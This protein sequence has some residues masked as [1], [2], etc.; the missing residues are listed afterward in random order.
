LLRTPDRLRIARVSVPGSRRR[1]G[2]RDA[3]RAGFALGAAL[4]A[5]GVARLL[6]GARA[7]T[8]W[9]GLA[10]D[11]FLGPAGRAL[12][13]LP[14]LLLVPPIGR[15]ALRPMQGLGRRLGTGGRAALA[16]GL[17]ALVPVLLL[18][19]RL[20]FIGDFILRQGATENPWRGEGSMFQAMPL[21][22]LIHNALPAALSGGAMERAVGVQRAVG[23]L[24]AAAFGATVGASLFSLGLRG[25]PLVTAIAGVAGSG[26]LLVFTGLGKAAGAMCALSIAAVALAA[27]VVRDGRGLVPLGLALGVAFH[28]HRSAL[29]LLP[30]WALACVAWWRTPRGRGE[31]PLAEALAGLG[32]PVILG[33]LVAPRTLALLAGFDL[34]RHAGTSGVGPGDW[35][36]S[37]FRLLRLTDLANAIVTLSPFAALAVFAAWARRRGAATPAPS[38]LVVSAALAVAFVLVA[39]P[40]QGIPR[41]LDAF[42]FAAALLSLSAACGI[43][44]TLA[45]AARWQWL[46]PALATAV[47]VPTLQWLWLSHDEDRGLA[48]VTR[49][50]ESPPARGDLERAA[51]WDFVATHQQLRGRWRE[52]L[53]AASHAVAIAPSPRLALEW[54]LAATRAGDL[55]TAHRAFVLLTERSPGDPVGW[56]GRLGAAQRLGREDEARRLIALL[57]A[58]PPG[59]EAAGRVRGFLERYPEI[60]PRP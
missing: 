40:Q 34:P 21:D 28:F 2:T 17:I 6:A 18:P 48:R 46:A 15:G 36:L 51:T 11:A 7:D 60:A 58:H 35:L 19:D 33:L 22:A 45:S 24:E 8:W 54:A 30:A 32:L 38:P 9:W 12:A 55:E 23:A 13:L 39:R 53:D 57:E 3:D 5:L 25:V 59:G 47:L 42:A 29:L 14:I 10:P 31:R 20:G 56:V 26:C 52:S 4:L 27:R 41:D 44:F 50:A 37:T 49:L 43:G 1:P 16:G